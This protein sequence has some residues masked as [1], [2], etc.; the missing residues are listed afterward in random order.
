MGVSLP[1]T[2]WMCDQQICSQI[3]FWVALGKFIAH[4]LSTRQRFISSAASR[5]TLGSAF[6]E[7]ACEIRL[8]KAATAILPLSD[9]ALLHVRLRHSA[10]MLRQSAS[11]TTAALNSGF[12]NLSHFSRSFRRRSGMSPSKYPGARR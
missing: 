10:Q 11:V 9:Q 1:R 12:E 6:F 3:L 5:R 8:F 2:A 7:S 4:T